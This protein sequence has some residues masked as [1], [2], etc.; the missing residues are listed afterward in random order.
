MPRPD[1][2]P[3]RWYQ[4]GIIAV[5]LRYHRHMAMQLRLRPE[6]DQMLEDLAAQLGVSKNQA[7]ATAVREAWESRESR[8]YTHSALDEI[9]LQRKGLLDRLAE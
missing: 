6:E 4:R 8:T 5:P 3:Q 7:V 9:S 1:T 2:H